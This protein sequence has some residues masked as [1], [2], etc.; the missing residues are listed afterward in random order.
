ML[1]GAHINLFNPLVSKAHNG[2]CQN[3][4]LP[5]QIRPEESKFK[6]KLADFYI[7]YLPH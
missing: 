6:V 2:E 7:F 5:L 1:Q 3:L 4:Q